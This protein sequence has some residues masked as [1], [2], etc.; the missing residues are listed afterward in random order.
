[1]RAATCVLHLEWMHVRHG[2]Q[3]VASMSRAARSDSERALAQPEQIPWE[4]LPHES[5]TD[6]H[7]FTI[8]RDLGPRRTID[9]VVAALKGTVPKTTLQFNCF[10]YR[11]VARAEA[12][13]AHLDRLRRDV[14]EGVTIER[15]RDWA[16]ERENVRNLT[17]QA[18]YRA[19]E[20]AQKMIAKALKQLESNEKVRVSQIA[21]L[22]KASNDILRDAAELS[23]ERIDVREIVRQA[24]RDAGL[25][26][27]EVVVEA[28][29]ILLEE[30]TSSGTP[31]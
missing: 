23:T 3:G 11:W 18:G 20:L 2:L 13:D 5:A 12:W 22:L 9:L 10:Q 26:P 25:N 4:R 30:G 31:A 24:A 27:D 1:M 21:L 6:Y 15:I 16:Q 17:L 8:Y 7:A 29:R 28:E 14:V 19:L